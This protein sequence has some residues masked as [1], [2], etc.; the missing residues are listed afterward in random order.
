[1]NEKEIIVETQSDLERPKTKLTDWKNE[2]TIQ[3]LK[4]DYENAKSFH[5]NQVAKIDDWLDAM[6]IE[7]IYKLEKIEGKS[8]VQP[9]LI[10]KQAEWRYSALSEPF[11]SSPNLFE[12]SP[13][14]WEDRK[15]ARQNALVLNNQFYNKLNR[16]KFI[17]DY[18]RA[19]V[20]EGTAIIRT[21]WVSE[22]KEVKVT[23]P[24]FEYQQIEPNEEIM[25][26]IEQLMALREEG[27]DS[28]SLI[29]EGS[30]ETLRL[31]EEEGILA[32]CRQ[33]GE[34][35]VTETRYVVNQPELSICDYH[36]VIPDPT[37]EGD[38]DK[39]NF[40]VNKF[41]SSYA[42]LKSSGMYENLERLKSEIKDKVKDNILAVEDSKL[43]TADSATGFI[44]SD[45]SR[46]KFTVYEYWGYWDTK[47][48]GSLTPIVATWVSDTLIRLEENPYP[49]GKIPFIF[50]PYSPVKNSLYGE[51]DAVLITDHQSI[52]GATTRGCIDLL[53]LSANSQTGIPRGLLTALDKRRFEA[54][55]NYEYNPMNGLNPAHSIH[56]HK[57]P[58]LP[59]SALQVIQMMANDADSLTGVKSFSGS[60]GIDGSSL[61][62]S[63][64]GVR[65]A[66]DAASK[67]EMG[68]LRR[69]ANGI[70]QL[71]RK[72]VAMNSEFLDEEEVVRITN[73][74]F[75]PIRKEDLG[76]NFDI[77]LS[78]ST[79]EVNNAKAQ[80]L[81]FLMQ[82]IGNNV[83]FDLTKMI[84][85]EI[86][87][88]RQMPDLAQGIE[89]FQPQ[90]DPMQEQLQ[91]LE[92][93][94]LEAEISLIRAEAQEKGAKAVVHQAKVGV[95]E[96]RANS[97]QGDA[98]N[99]A[100]KYLNE[101][102]GINHQRELEKEQAKSASRLREIMQNKKAD[103]DNQTMNQIVGAMTDTMKGGIKDGSYN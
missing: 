49:D 5:A 87:R 30:Q 93:A 60:G 52:I 48:D 16:T 34:K 54:G 84:M 94:K 70:V 75:I 41:E 39:C 73:E 32:L 101:R 55:E 44:F 2:P 37:C 69:L 99:K 91:Q 12:V 53:A 80:E 51:P 97:L 59:H 103:R 17:D 64:T 22:E 10:K 15:S 83:D 21:A 47:G 3:E 27:P 78:I 31:Y 72:I 20:N 96:A 77:K 65:G 14:S 98:D 9:K 56:T 88:L 92:M 1:M 19:C 50:V 68:I 76:G 24:V 61:G 58:E 46:K 23:K 102:E 40:V 8:S 85:G 82:T 4:E 86:A 38:M 29:D 43:D 57:Y 11:L 18:V 45:I 13:V 62:D 66:L 33:V 89:T 95:E 36:N 90:P 6:N 74:T 25:Q 100:M 79:A 81:A 42:D 71:G 67:R 26:E 7:G 35:E 63:A 28:F